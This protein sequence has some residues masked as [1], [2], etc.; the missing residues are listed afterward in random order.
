MRTAGS[1]SRSS[2][3]ACAT[4]RASPETD[5]RMRIASLT[6]RAQAV[7][8][9]PPAGASSQGSGPDDPARSAPTEVAARR[10]RPGLFWPILIAVLLAAVLVRAYV[11]EPFSIPSESME[12]TL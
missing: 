11:A 5:D 4:V 7:L 12:P 8:A 1:S 10:R 6:A 9:P 2:P 3:T